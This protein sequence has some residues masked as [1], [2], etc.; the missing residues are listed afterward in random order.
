MIILGIFRVSGNSMRPNLKNNDL[1]LVSAIP[2]VFHSPKEEDI[3]LALDPRDKRKI[4][5]R[6]IHVSIDAYIIQGDNPEESTDS[7]IF[8]TITNVS[9]LG[10]VLW[11]L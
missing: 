2:Y 7:R 9:I 10:K 4:V 3:I 1:I 8:G 6:I 11:K 5:K